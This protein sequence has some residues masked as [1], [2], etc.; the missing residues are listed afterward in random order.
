M[1]DADEFSF[2]NIFDFFQIAH[3][4]DLFIDGIKTFL[5]F[6]VTRSCRIQR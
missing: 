4:V 6:K 5:I 2:E 1:L 3:G